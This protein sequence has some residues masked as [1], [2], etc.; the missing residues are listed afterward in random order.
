MSKQLREHIRR[1]LKTILESKYGYY[2]D[3][4]GRIQKGDLAQAW[5]ERMKSAI[6]DTDD[7]DDLSLKNVLKNL[8]DGSKSKEFKNVIKKKE[9]ERKE[10]DITEDDVK[11]AKRGAL[12]A[13]IVA[14]TLDK[15]A[16]EKEGKLKDIDEVINTEDPNTAIKLSKTDPDADVNLVKPGTLKKESKKKLKD[17]INEMIPSLLEADEEEESQEDD[18]F[19]PN[20]YDPE[21]IPREAEQ[22]LEKLGLT[23]IDRYVDFVNFMDSIPKSIKIVLMNGSDFLLYFDEDGLMLKIGANEIDLSDNRNLPEAQSMINDLL[24][25]P[26]DVP[27]EEEEEEAAEEEA[28][29]EEEPAAE[30][31]PEEETEEP[32][33]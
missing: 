30:E 29:A 23:P 9:D 19:V 7:Q 33:T 31:E 26:I 18:A 21:Y 25:G 16:K 24:M 10:E 13:K 27:E 22:I 3:K 4:D 32:P 5:K 2:K 15:E 12:E 14:D 1:Q 17:Y 20:H 8:K 6:E 11:K 28:P